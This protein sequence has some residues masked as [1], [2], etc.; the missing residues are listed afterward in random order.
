[1]P[2]TGGLFILVL[3]ILALYNMFVQ[4][5]LKM[6]LLGLTNTF[7]ASSI[8]FMGIQQFRRRIAVIAANLKVPCLHHFK[9]YQVL[10]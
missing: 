7:L 1:M 5:N 9:T 8:S 10:L 2:A 4:I 3:I 6:Q